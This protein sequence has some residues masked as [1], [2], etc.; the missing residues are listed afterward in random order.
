MNLSDIHLLRPE[1]L[2]M[3]VPLAFGIWRLTRDSGRGSAW[4]GVVDKHLLS[5]LL[6]N[7]AGKVRRLPLYL[8]AIGGL[9]ASIA[10][11]GPVWE[12]LP[13][14]VYQ[15]AAERVIVLDI[16]ASMNAND[17]PPSR[18]QQA[19]YKVLDL[20]ARFREGQTALIAY[21]AEPYV[22]SPLT[23]D[24]KTIAAQVPRLA[25]E[26]LPVQGPKQTA[27]ALREAGDLLVQAGSRNGE[28]ILITD[29]LTDP[30]AALESARS[31]RAQGYRV[32]V[33]GIGTPQGAPVP[34]GDGG[35][36]KDPG[37]AILMP[38]L[39][40]DQLGSLAAVGGGDYVS[41]TPDD[42]DIDVLTS[43][44]P[45]EA[46]QTDSGD[47]IH[48]DQWREEGPWLLLIL[49]PLAALA[50]RRGWIAPLLL[51]IIILPPRAEAV[52]WPDL[53]SRPDQQAAG[54]LEKG[55]PA[56]A[57]Q[58]FER[59]DWRAAASYEAGNYNATLQ[60]LQG[61]D[62]AEARYN[63]GNALA[64]LGSFPEAIAE[65][66]KVLAVQPDHADARHNLDLLKRLL[67]QQQQ[68]Q[69]PENDQDTSPQT[70]GDSKDN[71]QQAKQ[72]GDEGENNRASPDDADRD[73][74]E[75]GTSASAQDPAMASNNPR[76]DDKTTA[77]KQ[78]PQRPEDNNEPDSGKL[79][80]DAGKNDESAPQQAGKQQDN[81]PVQ[82][83]NEP[84]LADLTGQTA[85]KHPQAAAN[86]SSGE[87][88]SEDQQAMEHMLQRVPDDPSGLLRQR[89]L[90]Q[91]LQ[92]T[93]QL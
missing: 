28:I 14:P 40:P 41:A 70:A 38:R 84:G 26:L 52:S 83:E 53:W 55:N 6:I 54:M 33:L 62:D 89:F 65:Y 93:G 35:F 76:Q 4:E 18:L 67:E 1:W 8:L 75:G 71:N 3:L 15:A 60:A 61:L 5:S 19:H 73:K 2:L 13:Q 10:L 64:R 25:T 24:A 48:A 27:M 30:G 68:K 79:A 69:S 17:L 90:L 42:R 21:G 74:K 11:A 51:T 20:L 88:M 45:L 36:L 50:F 44:D 49:L 9:I 12:R 66:E 56:G 87:P 7:G 58:K 63:R 86:V 77:D 78:E 82:P 81:P 85:P 16:S 22:V 46:P 91:H 57:A 72:G 43:Q 23:A 34:Q 47:H 29:G 92:R 80:E 59:P 39:D 31:L 37:G 32:S